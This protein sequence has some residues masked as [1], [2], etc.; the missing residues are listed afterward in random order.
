MRVMATEA[1]TMAKGVTLGGRGIT[2]AALL[3]LLVDLA[4]ASRGG[5]EAWQRESSRQREMMR[6]GEGPLLEVE[7]GQ[8]PGEASYSIVV[9]GKRWLTSGRSYL[10][11]LGEVC[12]EGNGKLELVRTEELRGVDAKLGEYE[13][14]SWEWV[15]K[16]SRLDNGTVATMVGE[17]KWFPSLGNLVL[18]DQHFPNEV[19]GTQS[20]GLSCSP[21]RPQRATCQSCASMIWQGLSSAFPSFA[22]VEGASEEELGFMEYYGI[23]E[24]GKDGAEGPNLGLWHKDVV[25]GGL[26]SGPIALFNENGNAIVISSHSN[27]MSASVDSSEGGVVDWGIMGSVGRI[28][29]GFSV[30][31]VLFASNRGINHAFRSWGDH[32]LSYYGKP[33]HRAVEDDITN[34]YLGYT[35]DNGAY[36]YY[37]PEQGKDM[38]AT[39]VDVYEYSQAE[40]IPYKNILLDSWWYYR[41]P[42]DHS[43]I[44]WEARDD[45]FR[46][47][48]RGM[49]EFGE[50][51]GW[52]FT[53]HNRFWSNRTE[54]DEL[55]GGS[56][57]F[58]HDTGCPCNTTDAYSLPADETFWDYLFEQATREWGLATYE[59]DWLWPQFLGMTKL[60]EDASLGR[61]WLLQ[62]GAAA[63]AHNVN[64][65][66]CMAFPRHAL[67]SLE[68]PAVTQIRASNDYGPT[69]RAWQWRIGR[70]SIFVNAIGLAPSKDGV[71]TSRTEPGGSEGDFV[72]ARPELE[73]LV[74][75]LSTGPVQ[76]ADGVGFSDKALI[77]RTCSEDGL[78]LKPSK[79][80]TAMDFSLVSEAFG[81]AKGE[82]PARSEIWGTYSRIGEEAWMHVLA[83]DVQN[84]TSLSLRDVLNVMESPPSSTNATYLAYHVP[85]FDVTRIKVVSMP[86]VGSV[87]TLPAMD[88]LD[89]ELWHFAKVLPNGVGILG[90][91]DKFVP[92]SPQRIKGISFDSSHVLVVVVGF[93]G[94]EVR[95]FFAHESAGGIDISEEACVIGKQGDCT[96]ILLVS[97][98]SDQQMHP[99]GIKHHKGHSSH[100]QVDQ[101]WRLRRR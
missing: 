63:S 28:P 2:L 60:L 7:L 90:E 22:R 5:N 88:P 48:N 41:D 64:I 94:E 54:Y 85:D 52:A 40:G 93:P 11:H 8:N 31:H 25:M 57:K 97:F 55:H 82:F 21:T 23:F 81:G 58:V 84:A 3:L 91:L 20:D 86:F 42:S 67:Q 26:S 87:V 77:M 101:L 27:F 37:N 73:V 66:Y 45:V 65:Q 18:F 76:I 100:G 1:A 70:S 6:E 99:S 43:V 13:G 32:M 56:F 96:I 17:I 4:C 61:A 92:T 34:E 47:G 9:D 68:V 80:M 35:T 29:A 19:V 50:Q 44:L 14:V 79:A 78:L 51:T 38:N 46:G 39:L 33:P 59:Q 83:A 62:M 74:A 69:D 30:S 98:S 16:Q 10:R 95:L 12:T 15:S 71:Y 49:G 53:A 75:L 36:Y 72:E 89:H 24:N